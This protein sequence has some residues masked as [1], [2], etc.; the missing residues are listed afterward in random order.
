M[1]RFGRE[2][3]RLAIGQAQD[4]I[5]YGQK[6]RER[7]FQL[8]S[9]LRLFP[10]GVILLDTRGIVTECNS[11]AA[12]F[13]NLPLQ[14]IIGMHIES[15]T[16]DPGGWKEV[17]QKG[18]QK[19]D[20]LIELPNINLFSNRMPIVLEGRVRGAIVT[21]QDAH[22]IEKLEHTYRK[23]QARGLVAKYHFSD[24]IGSSAVMA[25]TIQKAKAYS[26]VDSPILI[27][28]ETGTGKELFAQSIHNYSHRKSGPF[29]AINCAALPENLLESELMGYEEGAFTGARRGGKAGLFELAH[30][31]TIFLDEINQLPIQL[32]ARILRVLQEKQVLRLGGSRMIPVDVRIISASN[33]PLGGLIREKRFREDLYYRL[34]VLSLAIPPLRERRCDI[35]MLISYYFDTFTRQYGPTR[36][37]GKDALDALT[38]HF[39]PGNVRE[40][41]NCVE[42]YVVI[43]RQLS[44]SDYDFVR[45][46]IRSER[47]SRAP[48][49]APAGDP[50]SLTVAAGTLDEMERQLI[51]AML[52]RHNDNRLLT[53]S[54]LNISRTTLW[55]KLQETE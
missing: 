2:A 28:A 15:L 10:D 12:S 24:I 35:P 37:F 46:Y 29:V 39:W 41:V 47:K 18:E 13:F 27:E 8:S 32:Q 16:V 5:A 36:P 51:R 50:N 45:E 54:V 44:V 48:E 7:S 33:D 3:L 11:R 4:L 19:M 42:Q 1:L 25:E 49:E 30:T 34:K 31:G 6:E 20:Q 38:A 52:E 55:K 14:Q 23:H 17:Y 22:K 43:N 21:L 26:T 53:A 9:I 40:L